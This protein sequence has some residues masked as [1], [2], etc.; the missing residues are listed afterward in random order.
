MGAS[1]DSERER[2]IRV[3]VDERTHPGLADAVADRMWSWGVRGVEEQTLADGRQQL[4]TSV[5]NHGDSIARALASLDPSWHWSVDDV[6][7]E[8][9]V[10]EADGG[11]ACEVRLASRVFDVMIGPGRAVPTVK[12]R[13]DG[14]LPAK[15][16]R[17]YA[18]TSVRE[19]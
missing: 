8:V 17:E 7:R 14:G 9:D 12:C 3:T 4:S 15:P 11:W 18:V 10:R 16:G 19:R 5:G 1:N 2:I 13:A 6:V